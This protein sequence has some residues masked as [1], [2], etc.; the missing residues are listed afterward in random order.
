MKVLLAPDKFKGSLTAAEVASHLGNGLRARGF[1]VD[2]LPL[3]DGGDGSVAAAV[4]AGFRPVPVTVAAA[5]GRPH[6]TRIALASTAQDTVTAVVEVANTCGL[7]TLPGGRPAPL[8]ASSAGVGEGVRQAVERGARRIVLAL[9][10]SASTDGGAGLLAALAVVFRDRSGRDIQIAGGALHRV[11]TVDLTG[12]LDLTG[13]DLVV[14]GDVAN[15][16]TGPHGAA[17]V[18]GPQK[19]ASPTDVAALD[20]GLQHLVDHLAV[21]RPDASALAREPGA[22]AAGGLGFAGL[23][24]GGRIVSGADCFLDLL[25]FDDRVT[26]CDVVITGEG[27]IDD[28]TSHGKLPAVVAHR[29]HPRPVI[30]VVGRSDLSAAAAAEMGLAA[31]HALTDHTDQNPAGDPALSRSLLTELARTIPLVPQRSVPSSV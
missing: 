10:G 20:A 13:I 1:T 16:L 17:A 25:D 19:G 6:S 12:L 3:A 29:S 2:E 31:V 24:L 5:T 7:H 22:G 18:Y 30:A 11:A 14:A 23:L 9:G 4:A 26:D 21:L 27:R 15:P 8:E 28:Q